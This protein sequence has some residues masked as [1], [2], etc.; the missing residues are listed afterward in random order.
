M[1]N[2]LSMRR[3]PGKITR[4]ERRAEAPIQG[5]ARLG[6]WT[7]RAYFHLLMDAL[8]LTVSGLVQGVG[9]RWFVLREAESLELTGYTRNV[10]TGE[11]EVHAEGEHLLLEQLL[12]RVRIGPRSAH[13]RHVRVEWQT[14]TGR[15]SSFQII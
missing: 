2:R 7:C 14:P 12:E 1:K 9:F 5:A 3:I 6:S 11:V 4:Y 10:I 13:V 15:F 8:H